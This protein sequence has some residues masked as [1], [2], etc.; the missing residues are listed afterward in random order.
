MLSTPLR[1]QRA[2]RCA[3]FFGVFLFLAGLLHAQAPVITAITPARQVVTKGQNLTLSVTPTCAISYQWKRSGRPIAGATA[4]SYTISG[5]QPVRDNG[6]YQ[7]VVT[8]GSGSVTSAVM[9]VNVAPTQ[10]QVVAWGSPSPGALA[11]PAN[12][13]SALKAMSSFGE[14]AALKADGSVV[15]WGGNS[16]G[17]TS[18]LAGLTG[19]LAI[20][21][22]L[23]PGEDGFAPE[24]A[25]TSTAAV[26]LAKYHAGDSNHDG[27]FNLLELT[28]VIELYNHRNGTTRRGSIMWNRGRRMGLPPDRSA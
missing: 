14:G 15:A 6:W 28:R 9:F 1:S 18:V 5:A 25:R 3:F 8:N 4:A 13:T 21:A 16:E 2:L 20:S 11:V 24:P 23:N 17:Q 26:A 19:V 22:G 10:T 12:L 27:K 7:V